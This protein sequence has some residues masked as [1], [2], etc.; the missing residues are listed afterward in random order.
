MLVMSVFVFAASKPVA[1]VYAYR[2]Q[3]EN[4]YKLKMVRSSPARSVPLPP[5]L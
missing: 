4:S 3:S 5:P 1:C 2:S